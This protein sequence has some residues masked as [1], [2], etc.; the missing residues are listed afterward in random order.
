ML[1][2]IVKVNVYIH[3]TFVH[4]LPTALIVITTEAFPYKYTYANT[5]THN[6]A[7]ASPCFRVRG[8]NEVSIYT[9]TRLMTFRFSASFIYAFSEQR[10]YYIR[11][12]V[13]RS[14]TTRAPKQFCLF[15]SISLRG[16]LAIG[17]GRTYTNNFA[18]DGYRVRAKTH[19]HFSFV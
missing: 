15:V 8:W 19:K 3:C 11:L 9:E 17:G 2:H 5:G 10:C 14:T 4:F 1:P 16:K 7:L 12:V 18:R 13:V 6:W